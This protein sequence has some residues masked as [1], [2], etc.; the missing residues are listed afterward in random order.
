[1]EKQNYV[2]INFFL[3]NHRGLLELKESELN[4]LL[5]MYLLVKVAM[6]IPKEI[7][8]DGIFIEL[9]CSFSAAGCGICLPWFVYVRLIFPVDHI[10]TGTM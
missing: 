2:A 8:M 7:F 6:D 5:Y 10:V 3:S 1:M 4:L 9:F